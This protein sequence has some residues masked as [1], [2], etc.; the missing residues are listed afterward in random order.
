MRYGS[1]ASLLIR[2]AISRRIMIRIFWLSLD[3][4]KQSLNAIADRNLVFNFSIENRP[5]KKRQIAQK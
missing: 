2:R 1:T 3:C 5:G 4:Y